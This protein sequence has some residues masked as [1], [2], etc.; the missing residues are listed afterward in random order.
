MSPGKKPEA[1]ARFDRRTGQNYARYQAALEE[2]RG[3]GDRQIGLAGPGRTNPEDQVD[4]L[5]SLD[6]GAL[7]R[8][9]G[10]DDPASGRDLALLATPGVVHLGMAD[11]AVEISRSDHRRHWRRADRGISRTSRAISQAASEPDKNDHIAVRMGLNAEAVLDERQMSVV[12]TE[13]AGQVQI[14]FKSDDNT[15]L[16]LPPICPAGAAKA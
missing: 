4:G 10:F 7:S 3:R 15:L 9:A 5:Y 12:L 2:M 14:I 8:R 6:I 13:Q 1:L 11:H 16:G